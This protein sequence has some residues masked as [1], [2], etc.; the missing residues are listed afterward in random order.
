MKCITLVSGIVL[1]LFTIPAYAGDNEKDESSFVQHEYWQ[2]DPENI[3][4]LQEA[5]ETM[6][7]PIFD[8]LVAEGKFLGW[9]K[10]TPT[11]AVK[12]Y[13]SEGE[14]TREEI[15]PDHQMFAWFESASAEASE[16]AWAEFGE[17]L[18]ALHPEDPR[19]WLYC[20]ALIV[21]TYEK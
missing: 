21:V 14:A 4:A 7:A 17:R 19:P 20:D 16:A 12:K 9:G 3:S 8:D 11:G 18:R 5:I 15:E 13:V 10:L 2:C 1:A 6:H